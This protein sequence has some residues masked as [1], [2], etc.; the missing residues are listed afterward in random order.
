MQPWISIGVNTSNIV[1]YSHCGEFVLF[2]PASFDCPS[3]QVGL[4]QVTGPV[5]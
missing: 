1:I 5:L 3:Q 2:V 4:R